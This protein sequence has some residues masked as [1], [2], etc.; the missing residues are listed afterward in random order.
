MVNQVD[1]RPPAIRNKDCT[2]YVT[3]RE[4]CPSTLVY[5]LP[6]ASLL[7]R[8]KRALHVLGHIPK[9]CE[10]M[11]PSESETSRPFWWFTTGKDIGRIGAIGR[12][13][14]IKKLS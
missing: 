10:S 9:V 7:E 4:F 13:I 5:S 8:R 2:A 6:S 3:K 12:Y 11:Q 14:F 1:I